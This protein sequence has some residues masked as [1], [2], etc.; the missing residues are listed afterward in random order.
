MNGL[1][2]WLFP[3]S[4]LVNFLVIACLSTALSFA[5]TGVVCAGALLFVRTAWERSFLS[6]G[7]KA[8]A[9]SAATEPILALASETGR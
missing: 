3:R 9:E 6:K 7:G 1:E 5:L 2:R 8:V 4:Q